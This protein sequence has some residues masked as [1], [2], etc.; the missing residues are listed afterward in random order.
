M[1]L[2]LYLRPGV[3]PHSLFRGFASGCLPR[4][5]AGRLAEPDMRYELWLI[6]FWDRDKRAGGQASRVVAAV[7]LLLRHDIPYHSCNP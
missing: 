5:L 1:C 3:S 2:L 4:L 7:V 6:L